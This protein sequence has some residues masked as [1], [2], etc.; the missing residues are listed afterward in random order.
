MPQ[1]ASLESQQ[2]IGRFRQL[3]A[4]YQEHRDLIAVGAY[5]SGTDARV[6]DAIGRWPAIMNFFRQAGH[7]RVDIAESYRAL[8]EVLEAPVEAPVDT[9]T[10]TV[11]ADTAA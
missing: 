2:L 1:I 3:Y 11:I 6:D 9:P 10:D 4:L 5:R 8:E 7:E